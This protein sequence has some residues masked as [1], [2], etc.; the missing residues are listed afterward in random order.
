MD[1]RVLK[2]NVGRERVEATRLG[3]AKLV[4]SLTSLPSAT[5][6]VIILKETYDF[7]LNIY[8]NFISSLGGLIGG[9][10]IEPN[11][12]ISHPDIEEQ[13]N[14]IVY[15][16]G[17]G[18]RRLDIFLQPDLVGRIYPAGAMRRIAEARTR[19]VNTFFNAQR[20]AAIEEQAFVR[21]VNYSLFAYADDVTSVIWNDLS[22][23]PAW[24][25]DLQDAYVRAVEALLRPID[26]AIQ[27]SAKQRLMAA[28]Y[29]EN[30]ALFAVTGGRDTAFLDW[31][32]EALPQLKSRLE[33]MAGTNE[34]RQT[35]A[36]LRQIANRLGA[37]MDNCRS[38]PLAPIDTRAAKE[39]AASP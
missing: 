35:R 1:P 3:I 24:R 21:R 23:I 18:A 10:I 32:R 15:A 20:L 28:G 38:A 9:T 17:E 34:D 5:R 22:V 36:H 6:D 25:R 29:S 30:Y 2:E 11:G 39:S 26:T 8:S 37:L 13:R 4:S 33:A 12:T 16:L 31:A 19:I 7:A 14:A 27:K